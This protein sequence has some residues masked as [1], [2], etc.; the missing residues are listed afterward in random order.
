MTTKERLHRL[1]DELSEKEAAATL[2]VAERHHRD[3]LLQALTD[4]PRD[5]EPGSPEEERLA[6]E[7]RAGYRRGEA[8]GPGEMK[9]DLTLQ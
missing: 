6:D 5:D 9:Q 1:V 4:A 2:L 7:A 3:E 8:I